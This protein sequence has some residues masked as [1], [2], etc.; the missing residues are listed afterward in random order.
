MSQPHHSSPVVK[1]SLWIALN[2]NDCK[3]LVS[4]LWCFLYNSFSKNSSRREQKKQWLVSPAKKALPVIR[5]LRKLCVPHPVEREGALHG[6][7]RCRSV[8]R[9]E[10]LTRLRKLWADSTWPGFPLFFS[11]Q[12]HNSQGRTV[13]SCPSFFFSCKP[14]TIWH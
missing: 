4:P 2:V 11:A 10:W 5:F 8:I 7:K 1:H 9:W 6:A 13:T 3:V 14:D 12:R